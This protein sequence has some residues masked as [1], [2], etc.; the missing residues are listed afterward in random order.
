MMHTIICVLFCCSSLS[1]HAI[2]VSED[3]KTITITNGESTVLVYHKAEMA[4][5]EGADPS[6]A[7]SG[8][9]HPL[10]SPSGAVLTGIHP[11][12][13][14][15]HMGLWHAWVKTKHA[16]RTPDFWN[17]AKSKSG[18][19]RYKKTLKLDQTKSA[20]GF[21][22]TQEFVSLEKGAAPRV[23]L[24]E[25][26]T[27]SVSAAADTYLIDHTTVQKNV[28]DTPLVLPAYRY[29]GTLAYR[30]P[31]D[32]DKSNSSVVTSEGKTRLDGHA[33]RARWCS[34]SGP[35]GKG[36]ATLSILCSPS[37]HDAPQ[38]VRIWP[39]ESHDGAIFFNYVPIQERGFTFA[40]G[41]AQTMHYRIIVS[42]GKP[43]PAE[44]D[45][46]WKAYATK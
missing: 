28:T 3:D 41:S 32:W 6:Y 38:R 40:P 17:I 10:C 18:T 11:A 16:D 20:A 22:V 14:L 2:D 8:F 25:A 1:S 15:H 23:I 27:I 37:N 29:G 5:P 26:F 31:N 46:A 7:R 44:I 13:H 4:P 43:D 36:D 9:I 19:V 33:T 30:G 21:T 45:A 12:D 42:D 35:T 39:P 24:E 34:F